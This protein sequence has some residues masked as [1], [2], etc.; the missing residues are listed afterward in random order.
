MRR[1]IM[2]HW[3]AERNINGLKHVSDIF[4]AGRRIRRW[5]NYGNFVSLNPQASWP[6]LSGFSVQKF[7][8][9]K[10]CWPRTNK[11]C[12]AFTL[13]R[14]LQKRG[15]D[16]LAQRS[17]LPEKKCQKKRMAD[18]KCFHKMIELLPSW[19][20]AEFNLFEN[21]CSQ[22]TRRAIVVALDSRR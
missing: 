17:F 15:K 8:S 2:I 5:V 3:N 13:S 22:I 18:I 4:F 19:Y 14:K 11:F 9:F 1:S 16:K 10:R 12:N 7:L 21:S 6:R 20:R